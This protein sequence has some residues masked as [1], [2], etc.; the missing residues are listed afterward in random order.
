M[1][2][3]ALGE[4]GAEVVGAVFG[5]EVGADVG[6]NVGVGGVEDHFRQWW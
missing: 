6:S 2:D 4:V 5:T 1:A 3:Y